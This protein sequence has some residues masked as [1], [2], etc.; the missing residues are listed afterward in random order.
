LSQHGGGCVACIRKTAIR[1]VEIGFADSRNFEDSS[2]DHRPAEVEIPLICLR[3]T[4][5]GEK[6]RGASSILRRETREITLKQRDLLQFFRRGFDGVARGGELRE[7]FGSCR[8][9]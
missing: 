2:F 1:G 6:D 5:P 4:P 9:I 8:C 3:K 7:G